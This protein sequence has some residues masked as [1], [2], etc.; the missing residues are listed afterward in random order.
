MVK[1]VLI[2]SDNVDEVKILKPF[3][4]QS[5]YK[6]LWAWD[7]FEAKLISKEYYPNFIILKNSAGTKAVEK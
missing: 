4:E 1:N 6:V 5:G 2:C 3:L 7:S